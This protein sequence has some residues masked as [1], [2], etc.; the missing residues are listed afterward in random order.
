MQKSYYLIVASQV[1]PLLFAVFSL[2]YGKYPLSLFINDRN[3]S[4]DHYYDIKYMLTGQSVMIL[5]ISILVSL[6]MLLEKRSVSADRIILVVVLFVVAYAIYA[7][8][9]ISLKKEG[10]F[11]S[12][13]IVRFIYRYLPLLTSLALIA[14][15]IFS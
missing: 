11:S 1:A 6:L 14:I 10:F 2:I 7:I 9:F 4:D 3:V 13:F 5:P 15:G 12:G 8:Y